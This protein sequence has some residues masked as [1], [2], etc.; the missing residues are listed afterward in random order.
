MMDQVERAGAI[1]CSHCWRA[2]Q[3]LKANKLGKNRGHPAKENSRR[4]KT[5][6]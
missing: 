3:K 6:L 1:S 4:K 5:R 2:D